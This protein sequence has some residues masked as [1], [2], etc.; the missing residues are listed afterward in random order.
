MLSKVFLSL[1]IIIL[2]HEMYAFDTYL[3]KTPVLY[4]TALFLCA[5]YSLYSMVV[6]DLQKVSGP[7]LRFPFRPTPFYLECTYTSLYFRNY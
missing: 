1:K 7:S 6:S 4:E 5:M 2:I 3:G